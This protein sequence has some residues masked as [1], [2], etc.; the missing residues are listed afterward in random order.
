MP[1]AGAVQVTVVGMPCLQV[2]GGIRPVASELL[3]AR[4]SAVIRAL[5]LGV[6]LADAGGGAALWRGPDP[7]SAAQVPSPARTRA[8]AARTAIQRGWR[9]QRGSR[10]PAGGGAPAC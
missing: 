5:V 2:A 4:V 8:A 9:Y 7:R 10:R 1:E 3:S 6:G